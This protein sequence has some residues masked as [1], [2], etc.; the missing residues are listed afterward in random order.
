MPKHTSDIIPPLQ[1][2]YE[3]V[4]HS[5]PPLPTAEE[6]RLGGLVANQDNNNVVLPDVAAAY[7]KLVLHNQYVVLESASAT[8]AALPELLSETEDLVQIGSLALARSVYSY[9]PDVPLRLRWHARRYIERDM[10]N[11]SM[12]EVIQRILP[13]EPLHTLASVHNTEAEA[14]LAAVDDADYIRRTCREAGLTRRQ[15]TFLM[16]HYGNGMEQTEIA[17]AC[18]IT[19]QAVATSTR[20]ALRKITDYTMQQ[21]EMPDG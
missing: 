21:Q 5:Y 16:W 18:H 7:N 15:Q 9:N 10:H 3:T 6:C 20:I 4:L 11:W 14:M 19:K 12:E 8:L 1:H 2:Q 17:E 13:V